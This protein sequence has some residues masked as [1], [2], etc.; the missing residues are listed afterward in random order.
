MNVLELTKHVELESLQRA[1]GESLTQWLGHLQGT[2]MNVQSSLTK[3]IRWFLLV[4][5]Q[6]HF[7]HSV[8]IAKGQKKIRETFIKIKGMLFKIWPPWGEVKVATA[9]AAAAFPLWHDFLM[10][11]WLLLQL[12]TYCS[13][14][15]T[16]FVRREQ[17][18]IF[19]IAMH[20]PQRDNP[21]HRKTPTRVAKG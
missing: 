17:E 8:R 13:S 21:S 3:W 6:A 10:R 20:F 18:G 7:R 19:Q 2:K 11:K 12:L 1:A 16:R 4:S 9:A 15:S 5:N 14:Q